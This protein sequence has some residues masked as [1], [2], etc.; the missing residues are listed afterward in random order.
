MATTIEVP[1]SIADVN[2]FRR[3]GVDF[4]L[5]RGGIL[6][7][8]VT[9][10]CYIFVLKITSFHA[11]N[12]SKDLFEW[13]VVVQF[14]RGL[15][16]SAHFHERFGPRKHLIRE[17]SDPF[18]Q[19]V[20]PRMMLF[21]LH[22][23]SKNQGQDQGKNRQIQYERGFI[24]APNGTA[25]ALHHSV[26][27]SFSRVNGGLAHLNRGNLH[28]RWSSTPEYL[29]QPTGYR[30]TEF[31]NEVEVIA[32]HCVPRSTPFPFGIPN[33]PPIFRD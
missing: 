23:R 19:V 5:R 16:G 27:R 33:P 32:L 21:R 11:L 12:E 10:A 13:V 29:G 8:R 1:T 26:A 7:L 24:H 14:D 15:H 30:K 18:D 17:H 3:R 22:S 25:T 2:D 4:V 20:E 6:T 28:V 9:V 31:E